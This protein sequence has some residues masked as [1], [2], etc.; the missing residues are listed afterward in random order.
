MQTVSTPFQLSLVQAV[1]EEVSR[2]IPSLSL[3]RIVS[4][5]AVFDGA[6]ILLP[7]SQCGQTERQFAVPGYF[8]QQGINRYL[9]H[10]K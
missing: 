10:E 7:Y 1:W 3:L 5:R 6:W 2:K 9:Y 4:S 8:N